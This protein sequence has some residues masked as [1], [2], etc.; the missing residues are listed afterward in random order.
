MLYC[1]ATKLQSH[2][3]AI[4][5]EIA[6]LFNLK[7]LLRISAMNEN[8]RL[9]L[10]TKLKVFNAFFQHL[11]F[12]IQNNDIKCSN[13]GN[14]QATA[15]FSQNFLQYRLDN[16]LLPIPSSITELIGTNSIPI[17]PSFTN[18]SSLQMEFA[19]STSRQSPGPTKRMR[20][21]QAIEKTKIKNA[22]KS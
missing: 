9:V 3:R 16:P 5:V 10:G 6:F 12:I 7:V 1:T 18:V 19:I 14:S 13:L 11:N 17:F 20:C 22:V 21:S 8:Q 15:L 2:Y 4:R